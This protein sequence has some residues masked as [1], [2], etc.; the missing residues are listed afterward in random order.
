VDAVGVGGAL[1]VVLFE[2]CPFLGPFPRQRRVLEQ[3]DGLS[4]EVTVEVA[5]NASE[6]SAE[7]FITPSL[8]AG[9]LRVPADW[10]TSVNKTCD[11]VL[12]GAFVCAAV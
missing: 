9:S 1:V 11:G 8:I 4:V 3:F 7:G 2:P 6:V 10:K 5:A 12:G